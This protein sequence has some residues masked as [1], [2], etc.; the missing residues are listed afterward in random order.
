VRD[1]L[2]SL[3]E[4]L[5]RSSS[6]LAAGLLRELSAVTIPASVRRTRLYT[7][8][9][10]NT[11]RFV[12]QQVAEVEGAYPEGEKLADDFAIRRA[13]GNGIEFAGIVAFRAS[14]VWVLAA[15]ADVSGAGRNLIQ[16]IAGE[17]RRQGLL[18]PNAEVGT[19]DQLLAGLERFSARTVE[20]INTP[21]FDLAALRQEWKAIQQEA[22][23]VPAPA[24]DSLERFWRDLKQEAAAQ[25]RSVFILSSVMA[26]STIAAVPGGVRWLSRSTPVAARRTGELLGEAVLGHYRQTLEEIRRTGFL[27]YWVKVY[28]PYLKAAAQQLSPKKR[29]WTERWLNRGSGA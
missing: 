26:L 17:L 13:A 18:E 2:L 11:L 21:P 15:L 10:D 22:A 5:I 20:T 1:Y 27:R 19:M 4:R 23:K 6:G 12:I 8:L 9:V 7:N 25:D 16:E 28:R 24:I 3:P 14:P 29:T